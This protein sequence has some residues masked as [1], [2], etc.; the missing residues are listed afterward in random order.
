MLLIEALRL[1]GTSGIVILAAILIAYLIAPIVD[2][3]RRRMALW[4]ALLVTYVGFAA[5]ALIAFFAIV[6]P[7]FNE[8]RSLISD[9]PQAFAYLQNELL[10]PKN[11]IVAKLPPVVVNEIKT[12]PSQINSLIAKYG[13]GVAQATLGGLFSVV[14]LFLSLIIVPILCAYFFFDLGEVKRGFLGFIPPA[15][16]PETM[17]ILADL[18]KT[19]GCFVRGQALDGFILGT[20]IAVMLAIMHVRYALLIGVAAGILNLIPYLG[21]LV[22]FIPAVLLA[23]VFNGWE[24]ALIVAILFCVIQQLDGNVIL[25]R[26][27]KDSVQLS[28]LVIIMAILIGSAYF[29]VIG[30]FLAVPVAAIL[31]VLKLHFAPAPTPAQLAT[32]EQRVT[33]LELL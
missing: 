18:N 23:L 29:G 15:A 6:P 21:A 12:L 4:A 33:A 9:F 3:L 24:N 2:R 14:T 28:P 22:G 20:L 11:P 1:L 31:R 13:L 16:R 26:V 10:N 25:P 19:M 7:L 32:D 5:V 8:A 17:A 27:M 30:T